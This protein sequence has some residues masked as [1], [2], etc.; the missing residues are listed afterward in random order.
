[1][2]HD[3]QAVVNILTIPKQDGASKINSDCYA[4]DYVIELHQDKQVLAIYSTL[5]K[6]RREFDLSPHIRGG[7]AGKVSVQACEPLDLVRQGYLREVEH[8]G[9]D[10]LAN[11]IR[12]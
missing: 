5:V 10:K 2:Q 8:A 12:V 6:D 9:L 3:G 4:G 7:D 11:Y 1:M